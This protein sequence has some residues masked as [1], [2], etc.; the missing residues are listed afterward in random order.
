VLQSV[1]GCCGVLQSV[2]ASWLYMLLRKAVLFVMCCRMLQGITGSCRGLP[3][4]AGCCRVLQGVARCC[5]ES[6][7]VCCICYFEN[8]LE[9]HPQ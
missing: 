7:Q 1:T 3:G 9:G 2:S 8:G 6:V 4:V 5:S